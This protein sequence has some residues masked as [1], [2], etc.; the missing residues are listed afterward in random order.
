MQL[1]LVEID[2][3]HCAFHIIFLSNLHRA[4]AVTGM[5]PNLNYTGTNVTYI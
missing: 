4:V 1:K 5:D 2:R 3:N